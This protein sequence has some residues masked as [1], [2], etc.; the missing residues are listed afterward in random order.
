MQGILR[1]PLCSLLAIRGRSGIVISHLAGH[2]D[3]RPQIDWM[4]PGSLT[5]VAYL[6]KVQT[7]ARSKNMPLDFRRGGGR[8]LGFRVGARTTLVHEVAWRVRGVPRGW[9]QQDLVDALAGADLRGIT[10]LDDS[11]G[12]PW[13]LKIRFEEEVRDTAFE[14]EVEGG[15]RP[16]KLKLERGLQGEWTTR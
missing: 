14:V 11:F 8:C 5:G 3:L 7:A 2:D 16:V 10:I 4:E 12:R 15:F 13:L 9:L 6:R 1:V